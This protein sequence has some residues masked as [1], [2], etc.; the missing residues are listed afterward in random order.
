MLNGT[1]ISDGTIDNMRF[2]NDYLIPI[3][4]SH[5]NIKKLEIKNGIFDLPLGLRGFVSWCHGNIT[6]IFRG[7]ANFWNY[8]T[9]VLQHIVGTSVVYKMALGLLL[10][11]K[12][13]YTDRR[14]WVMGHSLGGGLTQFAVIGMNC[15]DCVGFGYNSAGLSKTNKEVLKSL[16]SDN[17]FHLHLK[18]DKVFSYGFQLGYY[19][20][21]YDEVGNSLK[22]HE[23]CAMCEKRKFIVA[24]GIKSQGCVVDKN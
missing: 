22:A 23:L 5:F 8:M 9:D 24:Y 17:V 15:K 14:F 3:S 19:V 21:Q 13:K 1:E 6:V 2:I 4:E 18:K 11:L 16:F 12:E 7:S 20:E 10:V